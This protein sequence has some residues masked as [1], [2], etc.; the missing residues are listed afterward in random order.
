MP[1]SVLAL[2]KHFRRRRSGL[3][4]IRLSRIPL[5][6][7]GEEQ[8]PDAAEPIGSIDAREAITLT[9]VF[10][11]RD[12]MTVRFGSE[13][14]GFRLWRGRPLEVRRNKTSL[15]DVVYLMTIEIATRS[16]T[17]K[18]K[19][20]IINYH[21]SSTDWFGWATF[22]S[23]THDPAAKLKR[24][25]VTATATSGSKEAALW[26]ALSNSETDPFG[27]ED[28]F[29]ARFRQLE[30]TDS[31]TESD[32]YYEDG[33]RIPAAGKPNRAVRDPELTFGVCDDFAAC[34]GLLKISPL[35]EEALTRAHYG[36]AVRH[37]GSDLLLSA[38]AASLAPQ[39]MDAAILKAL[40]GIGLKDRASL[41]RDR[42]SAASGSVAV[43]ARR[44]FEDDIRNLHRRTDKEGSVL[45]G[46][47]PTVERSGPP[48]AP[49]SAK[50]LTRA[51]IDGLVAR[52]T[53]ALSTL[54]PSAKRNWIAIL[55]ALEPGEEFEETDDRLST[56]IL[57]AAA[58]ARYSAMPEN[59]IERLGCLRSRFPWFVEAALGF[60]VD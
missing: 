47:R 32:A 41:E 2:K 48:V 8:D 15:K 56:A 55:Q 11:C 4:R 35:I 57:Y 31:L 43:F 6:N 20:A 38:R 13:Q 59:V 49:L 23:V 36:L 29:Y 1:Q 50:K 37:D 17:W 22:K 24:L 3:G 53:D 5:W 26:A 51:D 33:E 45:V 54:P 30:K 40:A 39:V 27:N 44:I 21:P 14:D 10:I 12:D 42:R 46:P 25:F 9:K 60:E 18:G 52:Y 16:R 28:N 19:T 34:R 58:M 7:P